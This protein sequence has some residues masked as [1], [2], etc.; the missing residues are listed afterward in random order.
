[1]R[2]IPLS[3]PGVCKG[4]AVRNEADHF[5]ECPDCGEIFDVRDL[6]QVFDHIHEPME[7]IP[8]Q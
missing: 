8:E 1:M 3:K 7:I 4:A 5:M 6:G 2:E